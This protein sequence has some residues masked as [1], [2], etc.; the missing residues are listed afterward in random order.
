MRNLVFMIF[1]FL[2][3]T[4]MVVTAGEC[5]YGSV[6]AWVRTTESDWQNATAHPLL[7]RGEEFEIHISI[8]TK[9]PLQVFFLKLHEFG[10]PVFEVLSG[11][12][13]IEQLLECRQTIPS[14]QTFTYL[15]KLRVRPQTTWVNGY[16][17]L[18][19]FVQ[20][21]KNDYDEKRVSFTVLAAYIVDE[22]WD[23]FHEEIPQTK[24]TPWYNL[25]GSLS[26]FM[27]I[28]MSFIIVVCCIILKKCVGFRY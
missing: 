24:H 4:T 27:T 19:F 1:V 6:H 15:W 2:V 23:D 11:P 22:L 21:N 3:S 18:E 26:E 9:I 7:K 13:A 8:S 25:G 5:R 20:F 17:P 16:G 28:V 12:T 14:N 10:T